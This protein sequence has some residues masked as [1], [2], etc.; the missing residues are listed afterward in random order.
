MK[1]QGSLACLLL[2]LCL[3]GGAA[4]PLHSGG[5]GTGASA[6]HGA[7]DAIS[8][9]IGEAV[10]QG[11]KEAASSGIQNALGQGHGEEGGSTLM[12]SRGDVFEHRLGEAARSLGNAGNEIGRQAE[13][14]IRQGVDAVHNAGS[15][16]TSGGHGAYGSQGGAGVQGNPGPQGTP[17]A[18]GGNYGTN[19]LGGSVGQGGN[20]GPLDYET[21][22]QGAVA[23][24]GYGTVRG[25]NQ[26]SGCTN[27]PPSGSH[28]SF[29]NSGGSS[30]D[31]SRGSQGSHGSNG[32]GSSGR[33]GGQGNS[34][35]N[36]SS[37]SSS[38][39]NSGNSNSGN[40]GNSNSGN[41]GNSGSGS[42]DIETS[43]F[44][45]GYSV[46]RGT[47]SRGGSGGSGGSGGGNKPECNNPGND[48]RMAGGSGSQ[49]H[50]S[51]GGNIQKE[52][53][54]GL[55]TMNSDASTLPFNIDNFWENL[56]SKTRFINWDAINKGHAPS[57]ST[58]ALLYFRKLWENF[59]RSTPFFNWKQI[60]GSDLSSLQKRAGGADQFSKPEARQDLSADSSKNYYN[61]QQ[62]NPTYN[63][64][65][66][67]K[68]TAKAGVTPSSSSASRAQ[69]GL[70][71]WL[72]FW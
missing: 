51:N 52:A 33:G 35:N 8:H 68:T 71:K 24:P 70:L 45:E 22:A 46:S 15:W 7:G 49:G 12:G 39:S 23:Q 53:V 1:L 5:E 54:N 42:R 29:S 19:S 34:D 63:W 13:D 40:S 2:A 16:G 61:N 69:P 10:G 50:G 55:N 31:G 72:K 14:I 11:A 18:S 56:K 47:G 48:V 59:K 6:A 25:N 21:N 36:G 57:P 60:E 37:S 17:W 67:T 9:G 30:N 64:Q 65:Y 20:G 28:E 66:Y 58:R 43:N 4:N 41:S 26:N 27:P 3:G 32:Q 62:V 44:D 38:G